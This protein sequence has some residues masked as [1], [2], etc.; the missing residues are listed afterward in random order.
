[1]LP[2]YIN[3][4]FKLKKCSNYLLNYNKNIIKLPHFLNNCNNSS[5]LHKLVI[6]YYLLKYNIIKNTVYPHNF[7]KN[8]LIKG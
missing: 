4:N 3:V 1:M 5:Y 8:L 2:F 7:L 6:I